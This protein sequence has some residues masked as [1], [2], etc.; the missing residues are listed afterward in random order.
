MAEAN[1]KSVVED[2]YKD[3]YKK[4]IYIYVEILLSSTVIAQA[5]VM[6]IV[7]TR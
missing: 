1:L 5:S 3:I 7:G 2:I 6:C 4:D